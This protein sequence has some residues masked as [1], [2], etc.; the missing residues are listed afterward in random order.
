MIGARRPHVVQRGLLIRPQACE[1][2][3]ACLAGRLPAPFGSPPASRKISVSAARG[4]TA[5]A[6][7]SVFPVPPVARCR[8]SPCPRRRWAPPALPPP[9][10]PPP[11]IPERL[12]PV[13]AAPP[14]LSK[15]VPEALT[16]V[17]AGRVAPGASTS[18]VGVKLKV[19]PLPVPPVAD[20]ALGGKTV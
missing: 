8:W 17:A 16:T 15:F 4:D 9:P 1:D 14:A 5:A 7:C 18:I 19:A 2:C 13:D 12:P 6:G 11:T 3:V 20:T 10:P